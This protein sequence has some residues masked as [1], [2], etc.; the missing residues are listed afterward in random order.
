VWICAVSSQGSREGGTYAVHEPSRAAKVC[1][2]VG[3]QAESGDRLP[4]ETPRRY[5]GQAM[6]AL[7]EVVILPVVPDIE[8]CK[9]ELIDRRVDVGK[10]VANADPM[11]DR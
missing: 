6:K 5:L 1:R 4:V 9:R 10:R 11:I 8:A 7:F 3:R 2:G